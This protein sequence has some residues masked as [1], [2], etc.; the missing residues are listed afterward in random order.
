MQSAPINISYSTQC[1]QSFWRAQQYWNMNRRGQLSDDEDDSDNEQNYHQEDD[2][3]DIFMM[4]QEGFSGD[5]LENAPTTSSAIPTTIETAVPEVPTKNENDVVV[6]E[7]AATP[8]PDT[9][10]EHTNYEITKVADL[11]DDL[12][13]QLLAQNERDL[14]Q[15]FSHVYNVPLVLH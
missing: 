10:A 6:A 3:D 15:M 1:H 9:T 14:R 2:E 11:S 12:F 4:A 13:E 7:P 8:T 5:L